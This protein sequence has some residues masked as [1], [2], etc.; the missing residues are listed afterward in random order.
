[1]DLQWRG[2]MILPHRP[3]AR[4]YVQSYACLVPSCAPIVR[5]A[6]VRAI[7]LLLESWYGIHA[8]TMSVLDFRGRAW[9]AGGTYVQ[10]G[11]DDGTFVDV[12]TSTVCPCIRRHT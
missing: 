3:V 6:L 1:M 2:R 5:H 11:G 8:P 10:A 9:L 4:T 12:R 7:R